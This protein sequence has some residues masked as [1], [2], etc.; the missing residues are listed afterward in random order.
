MEDDRAL[1]TLVF[2]GLIDNSPEK[3]LERCKGTEPDISRSNFFFCPICV[4]VIQVSYRFFG[5][6]QSNTVPGR[7]PNGVRAM[8]K[9]VYCVIR[10]LAAC[11]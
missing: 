9:L 1:N 8:P 4:M 10:K 3:C 6:G 7:H 11:T 5:H 2:T